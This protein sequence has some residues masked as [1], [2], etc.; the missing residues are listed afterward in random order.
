MRV[1]LN[2]YVGV[3]LTHKYAEDCPRNYGGDQANKTPLNPRDE[4]TQLYLAVRVF[5]ID[6]ISTASNKTVVKLIKITAS[7][8]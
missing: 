5:N 7:K 3:K 2:C 8:R 6:F 1:K 4:P